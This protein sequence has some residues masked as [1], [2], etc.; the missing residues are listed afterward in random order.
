MSTPFLM[1]IKEE[2]KKYSLNLKFLYYL[3]VISTN[4]NMSQLMDISDMLY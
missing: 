4:V 1:K 3:S 2:E